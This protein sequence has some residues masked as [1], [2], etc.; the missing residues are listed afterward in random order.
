MSL[1][2]QHTSRT[3]PDA[4]ARRWLL[5]ALDDALGVPET[6]AWMAEDVFGV[7]DADLFD[8]RA[9]PSGRRG[10]RLQRARI[11]M[12]EGRPHVTAA[13]QRDLRAERKRHARKRS[14][15]KR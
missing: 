3:A 8:F 12:R 1:T 9:W 2:Q 10:R 13:E 4:R 6:V 14:R 11:L 5:W 15:A 7:G